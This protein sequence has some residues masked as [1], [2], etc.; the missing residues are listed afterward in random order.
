L[1]YKYQ[2]DFNKAE[3]YAKDN[4]LGLWVNGV[5]GDNI[6]EPVSVQP[7][8]DTEPTVNETQNNNQETT[9]TEEVVEEPQSCTIKGNISYKNDEKIYHVE[10]CQSYSRTVI[11][12]SKG[13]KWFC[14]E[15]EAL[16]AGWRKALNCP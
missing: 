14:T 3:K 8:Q 5:C 1:P 13:E 12:E 7:T 16:A 2:G 9:K 11:D 15:A 10:G 4:K 6:E